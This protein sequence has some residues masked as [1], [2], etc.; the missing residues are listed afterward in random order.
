[1]NSGANGGVVKV[2]SGTLTQL[3]SLSSGDKVRAVAYQPHGYLADDCILVAHDG[4]IR[5]F[6]DLSTG[7]SYWRNWSGNGGPVTKLA[8]GYRYVYSAID[9]SGSGTTL[10]LTATLSSTSVVRRNPPSTSKIMSLHL[11]ADWTRL[12]IGWRPAT[13]TGGGFERTDDALV[14][15]QAI[16]TSYPTCGVLLDASNNSLLGRDSGVERRNGS[17]TLTYLIQRR[18]E[19]DPA[20]DRPGELSLTSFPNPSSGAARIRFAVPRGQKVTLK[21]YDVAGREIAT[22]ED[23]FV[24]AGSYTREW[25]TRSGASGVYFAKLRTES[26]T[27]VRRVLVVR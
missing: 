19:P 10:R 18:G 20:A 15:D 8:V 24:K 13:G 21:L 25:A 1:L 12:L 9:S 26:G 2:L 16:T 22:L 14:L 27:V 6:K 23:G 7:I 11:N 17:G 4:G 5:Q 3:D